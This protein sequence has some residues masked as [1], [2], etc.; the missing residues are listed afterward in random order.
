MTYI[1]CW[2][3]NGN[4]IITYPGAKVELCDKC[5]G[6]GADREKTLKRVPKGEQTWPTP[7]PYTLSK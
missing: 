1:R 2:D 5:K 7:L 6:T 3:C 4:G